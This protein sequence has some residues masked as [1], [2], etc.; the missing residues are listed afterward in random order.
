MLRLIILHLTAICA[1]CAE[2]M[3]V[4]YIEVR[5]GVYES[6]MRIQS[7][8]ENRLGFSIYHTKWKSAAIEAGLMSDA[9]IQKHSDLVDQYQNFILAHSQLTQR[10]ESTS[11]QSISSNWEVS[12]EASAQISAEIEAFIP[13]AKWFVNMSIKGRAGEMVGRLDSM[14]QGSVTLWD[15]LSDNEA[16]T[17]TALINKILQS[18]R[19]LGAWSKKAEFRIPPK[20]TGESLPQ[21]TSRSQNRVDSSYSYPPP[22]VTVQFPRQSAKLRGGDRYTIKWEVDA[23]SLRDNPISIIWYVKGDYQSPMA[24]ASN[25]PNS[26]SYEWIVPTAM[27][28]QGIL[29]IEAVDS[30]GKVGTCEVNAILVD[31]IKPK[32]RVVGPAIVAS[33]NVKLELDMK[34]EGPAGLAAAQLWISEDDGASWTQGPFIQDP[35]SMEWKA[36]A[37]G[38]YRLAIQASDAA[39]NTSPAPKGKTDDQFTITVGTTPR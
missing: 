31:S 10:S 16:A 14:T 11:Q 5:T 3:P 7:F 1:Y 17:K 23:H 15:K 2:G 37:D 33:R 35:R 21:S 29:K 26:G 4:D 25:I 28:T 39:G 9:T 6:A 38:K 32:A 13:T 20:S 18:I 22:Q 36:P 24:V 19:D 27:T 30:S 12:S 34:D 8:F